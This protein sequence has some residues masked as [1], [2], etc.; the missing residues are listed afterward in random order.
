MANLEQAAMWLL[1][2]RRKIVRYGWIPSGILGVV[3]LA[4][5]YHFGEGTV[6]LIVD[7]KRTVGTI[8]DYE[9]RRGSDGKSGF[10]PVVEFQAHGQWFRF[11]HWVG[12]KRW[13]IGEPVEVLY[14][15]ANPSN[16]MLDGPIVKWMP[17][18]PFVALGLLLTVS[19][20]RRWLA[21]SRA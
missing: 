2:R 15:A 11:K 20:L 3:L 8:V 21:M 1:N 13:Q 5:G 12:G 4:A 17:W 7:G 9:E 10:W 18:S 14:E 16:A 6:Q 19:A